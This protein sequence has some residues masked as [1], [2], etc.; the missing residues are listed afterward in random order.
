M[1]IDLRTEAAKSFSLS[2]SE[3]SSIGLQYI[4][5]LK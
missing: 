1:C 4:D 5:Y 2:L 3:T